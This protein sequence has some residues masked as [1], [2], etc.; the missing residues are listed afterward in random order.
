MARVDS[1]MLQSI[2]ASYFWY[3]SQHGKAL[4]VSNLGV[5]AFQGIRF[6]AALAYSNTCR[7]YIGIFLLS[8]N[9]SEALANLSDRLWTV[10]WVL[11]RPAT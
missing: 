11:S 1:G 10:S 4:R 7:R 3:S 5:G 6:L 2:E 8:S 9:H